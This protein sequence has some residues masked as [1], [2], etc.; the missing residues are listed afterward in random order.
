MLRVV[1]VKLELHR[2]TNEVSRRRRCEA[3]VGSAD[4]VTGGNNLRSG[5]DLGEF[6]LGKVRDTNALDLAYAK[7]SAGVSALSILE[8]FTLLHHLLHLLPCF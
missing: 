5:K 6:G 2:D 1:Q 7:R 3:N 4:L 8:L